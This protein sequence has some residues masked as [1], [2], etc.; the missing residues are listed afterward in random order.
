MI[1]RRNIDEMEVIKIK[2]FSSGTHPIKSMKRQVRM[3]WE[4]IFSNNV[5]GNALISRIKNCQ[6]SIAKKKQSN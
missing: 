3:E 6:N 5:S 1:H 4:K 2:N